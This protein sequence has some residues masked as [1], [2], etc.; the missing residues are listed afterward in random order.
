M[1]RKRKEGLLCQVHN[2]GCQHRCVNTRGSY[3][4]ECHLGSRLHVDGRTCL[5]NQFKPAHLSIATCIYSI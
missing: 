4:C 1:D 5:G 2:G 3:Y